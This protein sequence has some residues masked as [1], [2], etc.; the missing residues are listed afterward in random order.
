[1]I[2]ANAISG[3]LACAANQPAP[4]DRHRPNTVSGTASG[5]CRT[6][7]PAPPRRQALP[8]LPQDVSGTLPN[9]NYGQAVGDFTGA[10]HDQLAY[11]QDG[12][13]KIADVS[14]FGG[15]GAQRGPDRPDGD[16]QRRA[17]H[18]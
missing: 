1:M 12:Q 11:A 2:S 7:V 16:P 3:S 9:L 5:Q 6:L 4:G 15:S 18:Q 17:R 13:L 10:G 14:K 8:P